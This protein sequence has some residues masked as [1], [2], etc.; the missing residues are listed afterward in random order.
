MEQISNATGNHVY[1]NYNIF[2]ASCLDEKEYVTFTKTI[3]ESMTNAL[4]DNLTFILHINM[5]NITLL[6]L[7]K[8]MSYFKQ[9]AQTLQM[10]FPNKLE[11]G[12]VYN[13]PSFIKA[14]YAVFF[15]LFM[16]TVTQ[17]KII[18]VE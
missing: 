8:Y 18:I 4:K 5:E 13:A 6:D 9:L 16:D 10:L 14:A 15:K 17:K 7:E 12:Y 3:V 2:K 1:I 11:K